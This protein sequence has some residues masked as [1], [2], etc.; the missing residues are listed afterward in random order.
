VTAGYK[1]PM[2]AIVFTDA[3]W[4]NAPGKNAPSNVRSVNK[5]FITSAPQ[6]R[7]IFRYSSLLYRYCTAF[8]AAPANSTTYI[9]GI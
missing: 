8:D 5:D 2:P 4:P 9:T 3:L 1:Y 7:R 6:E